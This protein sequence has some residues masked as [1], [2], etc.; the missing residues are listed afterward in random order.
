MPNSMPHQL[1]STA[2]LSTMLALASHTH[3]DDAMRDLTAKAETGDAAAQ[4][5][6]AVRYRDGDGA[7]RDGAEATR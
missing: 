1:I 6:L 3:A 5:A 4:L 7:T 2:I